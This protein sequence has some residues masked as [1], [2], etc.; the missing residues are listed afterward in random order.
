MIYFPQDALQLQYPTFLL[1]YLSSALGIQTGTDTVPPAYNENYN[2]R[3]LRL[4]YIFRLIPWKEFLLVC[5]DV[6]PIIMGRFR[7]DICPAF[8]IDP[9]IDDLNMMNKIE[10]IKKNIQDQLN[11]PRLFTHIEATA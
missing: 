5:E 2:I 7:E 6:D 8:G 10:E 1:Q 4:M 3:N 11:K 9:N